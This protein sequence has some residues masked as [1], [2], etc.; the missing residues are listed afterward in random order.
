MS[1]RDGRQKEK[2]PETATE[3]C[4]NTQT[5]AV[6]EKPSL[7]IQNARTTVAWLLSKGPS[8]FDSLYLGNG[9]DF[10]LKGLRPLLRET[11]EHVDTR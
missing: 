4:F 10:Y 11:S 5:A 2:S 9:N 1:P 7:E 3:G 6:V 8:V